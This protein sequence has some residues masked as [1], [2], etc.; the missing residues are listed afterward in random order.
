[1]FAGAAGLGTPIAPAGTPAAFALAT[2]AL[3]VVWWATDAVPHWATALV[4]LVLFP[5]V[6]VYRGGA[7]ERAA[8]TASP[9]FEAYVLLFLGGMAIAAAL[10][11]TGLHRRLSL[12][13]L[14]RTRSSPLRLLVGVFAATATVSLWISNTAAA[15]LVLPIALA[16]LA[17]IAARAGDRPRFGAAL[18][19]AVAWGANVGGIGTK[20]GTATNMQL[21]GFL[22]GRGIE[23]S[24]V[25]FSLIGL[26]FVALLGPCAIAILWRFARADAPP[27]QALRLGIPDALDVP[28]RWTS[29]ERAV[30]I[31]FA[32]TAATWIAAQPL[33]QVLAST[34]PDLGVRSR[35]VEA[36]A[37]LLAALV[38]AAWRPGGR[39]LLS[40][41]ALRSMPWSALLLI[42]GSFAL[43]SGIEHS[44]LS[45]SIAPAFERLSTLPPLAQSLSVA[46]LAVLAS[47]FASNT[48][49]IAILLPLI[50]AA[51]PAG[52]ETTLLF[53]ATIGS[54]CDFA[55]PAGTPP[56]AI[57]LA[58][59]RVP[60]LV[61]VRAGIALDVVAAVLCALW[62]E[63]VV[64][65]VVG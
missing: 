46:G 65:H 26:G 10:Q 5:V 27:P 45:D 49:T 22:T 24:F 21:A 34:F 7:L 39:A 14:A 37:A 9:Y 18:V 23:V 41:A 31:V 11:Q 16:L 44:G 63:L 4:P 59:G 48:A 54:S 56:N 32:L 28:A 25:E 33:A 30:G 64:R 8:A 43:A 20:I 29:G 2:V 40:G 3:M 60:F 58:S 61:M 42:G 55:L 35:H 53:A 36:G 19:L 13:I 51:A 57:A 12:W 50:A 52:R 47:A 17:E 62:C 38:L 1:M 6:G 15:A